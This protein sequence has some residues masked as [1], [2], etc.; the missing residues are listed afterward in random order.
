[1]PLT[2]STTRK[3][4]LIVILC[5]LVSTIV[6]LVLVALLAQTDFNIMGLYALIIPAG[7]ML[8]G[9]CSGLGYYFG[10][11]YTQARVSKKFFWIVFAISL[12]GYAGAQ[13][14]TYLALVDTS[15]ITFLQYISILVE[16]STYKMSDSSDGFKLGVFGYLFQLLEALGF[17]AGAM[18]PVILLSAAPYCAACQFYLK[19]QSTGF[20]NSTLEKPALKKQKKD[21]KKEILVTAISEVTAQ[22]QTVIDQTTGTGYDSTAAH[23]ATLDRKRNGN[24]LAQVATTLSKCP[25]CQTHHLRLLLTNRTVEGKLNSTAIGSFLRPVDPV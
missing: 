2:T 10:S 9:V 3:P 23:I 1:M 19:K 8:V 5:G 4:G 22:A 13:Y 17:S 25:L 11:R 14:V 16:N 18:F 7:A 21:Q 15:K 12:A 6:T 24:T 20:I